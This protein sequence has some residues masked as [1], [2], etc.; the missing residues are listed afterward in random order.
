MAVTGIELQRLLVCKLLERVRLCVRTSSKLI[1]RFLHPQ[2]TI[3]VDR[4]LSLCACMGIAVLTVMCSYIVLHTCLSPNL[5]SVQTHLLFCNLPALESEEISSSFLASDTWFAPGRIR[6]L[7][8]CSTNCLKYYNSLWEFAI[9]P[10]VSTVP[11]FPCTD[12]GRRV[13]LLSVL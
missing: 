7:K 10:R 11:T 13:T 5:A 4:C 12:E 8:N 9:V 6:P 2:D 1:V 3:E